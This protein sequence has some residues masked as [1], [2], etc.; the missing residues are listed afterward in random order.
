MRAP[1]KYLL[2]RLLLIIIIIIN[3]N[4]NNKNSVNA[5]NNFIQVTRY[6]ALQLICD[7]GK[8]FFGHV[9]TVTESFSC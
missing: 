9:D 6:S 8:I 7:T 1:C 5:D 2:R 3:N 4:N